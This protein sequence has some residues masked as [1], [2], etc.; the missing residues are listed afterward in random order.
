MDSI[1]FKSD[2]VLSDVH[3]YTPN[4]RHLMV[5][6]NAVGQPVFVSKFKILRNINICNKD[7]SGNFSSEENRVLD[8]DDVLTGQMGCSYA[9][10]N[11]KKFEVTKDTVHTEVL[12]D[13]D[14][15]LD[16][17]RRPVDFLCYEENLWRE[18]VYPTII[19]KGEEYSSEEY[20]EDCSTC[21]E[22]RIEHTMDTTLEDVGKQVWRGAFLL[23][24]YI[25]NNSYLFRDCTVLELGAGTGMTSIVMATVAKTIYCTDVGEDLLNM[26]ERNII[27]NKHIYEAAGSEIKVREL[28]W[29]RDDLCTDTKNPYCWSEEEIAH[30]YDHTDVLLAADVFYDDDLTDAFFQTIYRI[31]SNLKNP[32]TIYLSVEKRLNFTLR[33][34]DV[35][36]DAY[37]HFRLCLADLENICDGRTKFIVEPIKSSFPQFL[38]YERVE[39]LELW[40]IIA[41][42]FKSNTQQ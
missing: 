30:M 15:D 12:L 31:L 36:C 2:T 11:E 4:I 13:D 27:V 14:G 18:K 37:D 6:L 5:R 39:Q 33:K 8:A 34:M 7:D 16:V 28:D 3:M 38:S 35:T 26:C 42:P 23:A 24:D 17:I 22:I 41:E 10:A 40:K 19:S 9:A 1:T 32:S 29:L 25:W 21:K 20:E